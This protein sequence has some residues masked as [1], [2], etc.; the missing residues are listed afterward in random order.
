MKGNWFN[1]G[2]TMNKLV[3]R[4]MVASIVVLMMGIAWYVSPDQM[5]A[6]R[7]NLKA[8]LFENAL[9]DGH[10]EQALQEFM[11]LSGNGTYYATRMRSLKY[12]F[13]YA[14]K[15]T[16]KENVACAYIVTPNDARER[17]GRYCFGMFAPNGI[18]D[19]YIEAITPDGN[20]EKIAD[21]RD[22]GGFNSYHPY[23]APT[24]KDAVRTYMESGKT[25]FRGKTGG[26]DIW[27]SSAGCH[28]TTPG[29]YKL[30][31]HV[32]DIDG[33]E[34]TAEAEMVIAK[35]TE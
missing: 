14:P 32:I 20:K 8:K 21:D 17:I 33:E 2:R 4:M 13:P 31:L 19:W 10:Y 16:G 28:L 29:K 27:L 26:M 35:K 23:P 25:G 11:Q 7:G 15:I 1:K 6:R 18:K 30:I 9:R 5:D 3:K 22:M 12:N 34:I 24:D